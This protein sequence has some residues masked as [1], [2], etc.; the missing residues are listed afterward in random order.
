[1]PPNDLV[2]LA[3]RRLETIPIENPDAAVA[4]RN[5]PGPLQRPHHDRD[6]RAMDAQH[7]GEELVLQQELVG[8]DAS[9]GGDLPNA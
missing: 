1:V 6:R 3:R 4:G 9:A 2:A 8:V 5:E 7:D